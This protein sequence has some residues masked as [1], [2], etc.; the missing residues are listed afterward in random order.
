M[1]DDKWFKSYVSNTTGDRRLYPI[2]DLSTNLSE[3]AERDILSAQPGG[4]FMT[5]YHR[6][7][8]FVALI[9]ALGVSAAMYAQQSRPANTAS[10]VAANV[11]ND[12]LRRAGG[13]SDLLP[14]AWL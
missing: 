6:T 10:N 11:T 8:A 4:N 14:G 13:A 7:A 2:K 9:I 12:V 1:R 5:R 3:S